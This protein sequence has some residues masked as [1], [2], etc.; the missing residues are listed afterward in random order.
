M[1]LEPKM[2][3]LTLK[4][5]GVISLGPISFLS[6]STDIVTNNIEVS[7][8]VIQRADIVGSD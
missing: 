6:Y 3:K 1:K 2:N 7:R 4:V 8:K 5:L